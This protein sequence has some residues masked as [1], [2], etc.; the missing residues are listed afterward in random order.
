MRKLRKD[1]I[2]STAFFWEK[3][4]NGKIRLRKIKGIARISNKEDKNGR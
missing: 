2:K 1:E 4:K 3:S